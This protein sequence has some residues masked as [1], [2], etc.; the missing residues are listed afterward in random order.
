MCCVSVLA[1]VGEDPNV[2]RVRQ[3]RQAA[4]DEKDKAAKDAFKQA[5]AEKQEFERKRFVGHTSPCLCSKSVDELG[6]KVH[7]CTR[8]GNQRYL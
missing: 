8:D 2:A 6:C 1:C 7:W 3:Q 4:Q 5:M